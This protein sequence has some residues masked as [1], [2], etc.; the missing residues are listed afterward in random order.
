MGRIRKSS[1]W[2]PEGEYFFVSGVI[3]PPDDASTIKRVVTTI[4]QHPRVAAL[5]VA[6][7]FNVD[8]AALEGHRH[9][10][11]IVAAITSAGLEDIYASLLTV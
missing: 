10:E 4:G 5:L 11:E 7:K 1:N 6:K 2:T 3:L 8:L 9:G